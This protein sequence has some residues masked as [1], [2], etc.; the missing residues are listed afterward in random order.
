MSVRNAPQQT[1]DYSFVIQILN[2]DLL[3]I[4]LNK[5]PNAHATLYAISSIFYAKQC[6]WVIWRTVTI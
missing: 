5:I 1:E 6:Y 2:S 4:L 3:R